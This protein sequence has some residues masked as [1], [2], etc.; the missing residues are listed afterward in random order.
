MKLHKTSTWL[1][2]I[3]AV[4]VL[5][6]CSKSNTNPTPQ[7]ENP[8]TAITSLSVTSGPFNTSVIITGTAFS[9]NLA[10]DQVFFNGKAATITAATT[11]QITATVPKGAGTGVV[12]I[13]VNNSS[14]IVG[15][16]FTY[17]LS[18]V[19]STIAGSTAGGYADGKGAAAKFNV[20]YRIV[21][22]ANGNLFVT[23]KNNMLVRK[24]T[25]DGTVT[26]LAGSG[27]DGSDDG[28]GTA[29]SFSEP[30]GISFD[31]K[32]NLLVTD[33]IS[34]LIRKITPSGLVST[35][36]V[37]ANQTGVTNPLFAPNGIAVDANNN[38]YFSSIW[39]IFKIDANQTVA[40]YAGSSSQSGFAD[41]GPIYALL[42]SPT[43]IKVDN[44]GNLIFADAGA[45]RMVDKNQQVTTIA[46]SKSYGFIDGKGSIAKF[47]RPNDLAIDNKGNIYVADS[48]NNS[49]RMITADGT[50]TTIAGSASN[51]NSVDGQ[52]T[53]AGF[54]GLLGICVDNNGTIYV[55]DSNE[56]RKIVF[57]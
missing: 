46:G 34:G 32:G 7:T 40:G 3:I 9:T 31:T 36:T 18:A 47:T 1:L 15:P 44:N 8:P 11:T 51:L 16:V 37:G 2:G 48:G 45:I 55:T 43:G 19:V 4:L 53:S 33:F 57:E 41:G 27:K 39:H 35:L 54:S 13:I 42:D 21:A 14:P 28:Q 56:I 12:S 17:Q 29:A 20:A 38:I 30:L 24:V 26:T 50:V 23:D 52:G 49:I 25:P 22:D 10:S 6:S 5:D